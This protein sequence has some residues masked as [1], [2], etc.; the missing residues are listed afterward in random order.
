MVVTDDLMIDLG[1]KWCWSGG[2]G[3][4]MRSEGRQSRTRTRE[5]SLVTLAWS[6]LCVLYSA[7]ST[8]VTTAVCLVQV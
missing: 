6:G 7:A 5:W 3:E 4:M 2:D 8:T 1:D